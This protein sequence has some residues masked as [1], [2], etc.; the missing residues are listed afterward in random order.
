MRR[1]ALFLVLAGCAPAPP[2]PP[3]PPAKPAAHKVDAAHKVQ[4]AGDWLLTRDCKPP[5][6]CLATS[7]IQAEC[8]LTLA[9]EGLYYA[10]PNGIQA[11]RW[12]QIDS[13][14]L[15]D[16]TLTIAS[17]S[18][19]PSDLSE[20]ISL[21]SQVEDSWSPQLP[22]AQLLPELARCAG[23]EPQ[24]EGSYGRGK[25]PPRPPSKSRFIPLLKKAPFMISVNPA[26]IGGLPE[27]LGVYVNQDGVIVCRPG[28]ISSIRW[29]N[30][31]SLED[32]YNPDVG[33]A[34][35]YL[36]DRAEAV[37]GE[38]H[39]IAVTGP[40][41]ESSCYL[42]GPD[43]LE[44]S[45][46]LRT[47]KPP[48]RP[49][50]FPLCTNRQTRGKPGPPRQLP[51]LAK[52]DA[53]RS[54]VAWP[55]AA[56]ANIHPLASGYYLLPSGCFKVTPSTIDYVAWGD[57]RFFSADNLGNCSMG[58]I[59]LENHNLEQIPQMRAMATA[60]LEILRFEP[61][62]RDLWHP[63]K[64]A[65]IPPSFGQFVPHGEGKWVWPPLEN[66]GAQP[67][68]P[69]LHFQQDAI[70]AC[71]PNYLQVFLWDDLASHELSDDEWLLRDRKGRG[72]QFTSAL[73]PISKEVFKRAFQ[74]MPLYWKATGQSNGE[75]EGEA[76]PRHLRPTEPKH[77]L[78]K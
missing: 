76:I 65:P 40:E 5:L 67:W 71:F 55:G 70:V 41:R 74:E 8:G 25:S 32:R 38:Y 66:M 10:M 44:L 35:L 19:D 33:D 22:T 17:R 3:S 48:G 60:I 18:P 26:K 78:S 63:G 27:G 47:R 77:F 64:L 31:R 14:D 54:P 50:Y 23:L 20:V 7:K 51:A 6:S 56:L 21:S 43:Y 45:R 28:E 58:D 30:F 75:T 34:I 73:R 52:V 29:S 61:S 16:K 49:R 37:P 36:G 59:H 62:E 1:L 68:E 2:R 42:S 24:G 46:L 57:V 13:I 9:P 11:L 4:L 72:Q 53:P 15:D 39:A 69:G 12:D